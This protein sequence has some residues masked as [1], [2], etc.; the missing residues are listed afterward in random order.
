MV[1]LLL[2]V[3]SIQFAVSRGVTDRSIVAGTLGT[4]AV[5][6]SDLLTLLNGFVIVVCVCADC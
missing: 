4:K 1:L 3:Y 2:S 6:T 5:L